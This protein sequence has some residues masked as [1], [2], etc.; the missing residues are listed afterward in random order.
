[1]EQSKKKT[2]SPS[3]F[4]AKGGANAPRSAPL[5]KKSAAKGGANAPRS[6]PLPIGSVAKPLVGLTNKM[7]TQPKKLRRK[8]GDPSRTIFLN[9]GSP[10]NEIK[11]LIFLTAAAPRMSPSFEHRGG[12]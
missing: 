11:I 5:S 1:V 3:F 4:G 8:L 10:P 2:G 9:S 6:A 12:R 7:A